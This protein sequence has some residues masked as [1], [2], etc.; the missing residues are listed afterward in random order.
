MDIAQIAI[1]GK[2]C[3]TKPIHRIQ[4]FSY[5]DMIKALADVE[6]K[7]DL[8]YCVG[9]LSYEGLVQLL[10]T[11][12]GIHANVGVDSSIPLLSFVCYAQREIYQSLSQKCLLELLQGLNYKK[13]ITD[14]MRI[15]SYIQNGIS[16]QINYTQEIKLFSHADGL[17]IFNSIKHYQKT[18]YLSYFN[19]DF[20]EIVGFSPELFFQTKGRIL[21][22]Q[23][24]KGTMSRNHN[25]KS[26]PTIDD[27]NRS[28]NV[29]IVDLLRNDLHKLTKKPNVK[30]TSLFKILKFSTLEQMVSTIQTKISKHTT[31]AD[32]FTALGPCGSITGAPKLKT[33][34]LISGLESRH[35]GV[36]C[37]AFGVVHKQNAKFCI[38]IR[39]MQRYKHE[40]F[41]R[42]GVGAGIVWDST[43]DDE[44][45]EFQLK[46][47]FLFAD[48]S[49]AI[50]ETCLL[51]NGLCFLLSEHIK[52]MYETAKKIQFQTDELDSLCGNYINVS[53]ETY[54][55]HKI[56]EF[57]PHNLPFWEKFNNAKIHNKG[58]Y[59][60]RLLLHKN[61][62][63]EIQQR[64]LDTIKNTNVRLAS[65]PQQSSNDFLYYKTTH[66]VHYKTSNDAI[67]SGS[68]YDEIHYNERDEL[69]EASRN[70][71]ILKIKHEFFTPPLSSGLLNGIMR[72]LLL[73]KGI[74]TERI[75]KKEDIHNADKIY[76]ANSVRG[77]VE[78]KLSC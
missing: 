42:Y 75:L 56:H 3:Y 67:T 55:N 33:I 44:F 78:V 59:I 70:N 20:I 19:D 64:P 65:H 22:A 40:H 36:Y 15:K 41:W 23:P 68:C 72:K 18:A 8:G 17:D 57:L 73:D 63:L 24:M 53:H 47:S 16:Y 66:R 27:K 71:L 46:T 12:L 58:D 30:V 28:E 34:E 38:P 37:G 31:L 10:R 21:I 51:S 13:F 77:V 60:V 5:D 52:R 35:R 43:M 32:I 45:K 62:Q 76:L 4:A 29:M 54:T 39:T 7:S 11:S 49:F 69:T 25:S 48:D 26:L 50:L 74:C 2:Y 61:G 1:F 14:F 9:Y 6:Q